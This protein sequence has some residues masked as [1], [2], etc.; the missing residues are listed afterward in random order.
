MKISVTRP[1]RAPFSFRDGLKAVGE[2]GTELLNI[3]YN[4]KIDN[5]ELIK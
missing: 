4:S 3:I 1:P 2:E 5:H